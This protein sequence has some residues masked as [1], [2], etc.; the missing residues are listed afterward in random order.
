MTT[1]YMQK[2]TNLKIA[3][4]EDDEDDREFFQEVLMTI[5]PDATLKFYKNGLELV[6]GLSENIE[7]LPDIVFL[8]LNMPVMN[9]IQ[10]LEEIRSKE[11]FK[12][13]PVIAIYS[14]SALETDQQKT[15]RLGADAFLSKPND[16]RD[17]KSLLQQVIETDWK[18]KGPEKLNFVITPE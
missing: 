8:D 13:I 15:F 4:A 6:N 14:T 16:Y 9:G 10:A 18:N 2:T 11:F 17:L 3:L 7:D 1:R 12:K 5:A